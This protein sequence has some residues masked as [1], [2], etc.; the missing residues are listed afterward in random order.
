MRSLVAITGASRG[1]GR[2]LSDHL[3]AQ[4]HRVY[5]GA[6]TSAED[7]AHTPA[8]PYQKVNTTDSSALKNWWVT[9]LEREGDL[10]QFVVANAGQINTNAP[11][12]Q[13]PEEEFRAVLETNVTGVYLTFKTY[14]EAYFASELARK[15]TPRVLVALSSTWGRSVSPEVAPY[16]ASKWAVEGL[17]KAFSCEL[18]EPLSVVALNPGVIATDMLASCFGPEAGPGGSAG[19]LSTE[20]WAK[21]A[22]PQILSYTRAHNGK[23]LNI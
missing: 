13:V 9:I 12:W 15:D 16:C 19:Y 11:L 7:L 6:R 21:L 17:V 4:G 23:S 20:A 18:P 10:P 14:L 1:L 22:A 3:A 5:G 8:Y 2:A